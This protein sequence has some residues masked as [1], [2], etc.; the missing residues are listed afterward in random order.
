MD[1][2]L[3]FWGSAAPKKRDL[4]C[5]KFCSKSLASYNILRGAPLPY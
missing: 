3:S 5:I 1:V 4:Y 2:L